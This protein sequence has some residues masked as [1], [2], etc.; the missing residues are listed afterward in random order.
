MPTGIC[1][2]SRRSTPTRS[3]H[4]VRVACSRGRGR[5]SDGRALEHVAASQ[6][7]ARRWVIAPRCHQRRQAGLARV[8]QALDIRITAALLF[9]KLAPIVESALA[10]RPAASAEATALRFASDLA[11]IKTSATERPE[12]VKAA[13]GEIAAG[14]RAW[15]IGRR[16]HRG[17]GRQG[18]PHIIG[19]FA[20]EVGL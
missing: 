10:V 18:S 6:D 14:A 9:W 11:D 8:L 13:S 2:Q 17:Q 15:R 7:L 3:Q 5:A 16:G 20:G 12:C 4:P 19:E 1:S